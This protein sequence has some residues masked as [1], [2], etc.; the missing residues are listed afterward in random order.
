MGLCCSYYWKV[1]SNLAEEPYGP[2][3]YLFPQL[4]LAK[5]G[6]FV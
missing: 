4:Y 6:I 1:L 2:S 5:E 3:D